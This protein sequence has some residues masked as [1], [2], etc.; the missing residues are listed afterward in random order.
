V[1]SYEWKSHP[2]SD[3]PWSKEKDY[4]N[5]SV[6]DSYS[7]QPTKQHLNSRG[8]PCGQSAANYSSGGT[9]L[10]GNSNQKFHSVA[11]LNYDESRFVT[12]NL[13]L[14]AAKDEPRELK[15]ARPLKPLNSNPVPD[16]V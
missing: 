2:W 10:S 1:F 14:V 3:R 13:R 7:S 16:P 11:E 15:S 6:P 9:G 4:Y 8:G 5:T 12:I